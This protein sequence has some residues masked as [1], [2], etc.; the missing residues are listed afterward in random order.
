M[1]SSGRWR[2]HGLVKEFHDRL[3]GRA[4]EAESRDQEPTA[5]VIDSPVGQRRRSVP[6]ASHGYDGGKKTN[7]TR[8]HVITEPVQCGR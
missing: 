8:R 5:A 6:A 1:P 3:H 2:E 4:R 7:K